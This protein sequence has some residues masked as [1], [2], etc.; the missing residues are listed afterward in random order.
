MALNL[1]SGRAESYVIDGVGYI[2]A[3][4]RKI[5]GLKHLVTSIHAIIYFEHIIP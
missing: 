5:Y 2:F 1:A 4:A 3:S